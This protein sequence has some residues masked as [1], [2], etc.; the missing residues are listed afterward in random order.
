MIFFELSEEQAW[1][2]V[3]YRPEALIPQKTANEVYFVTIIGID[4]EN[5]YDKKI[6]LTQE[7]FNQFGQP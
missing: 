6:L 7:K 3:F 4:R 5:P 1:G 2:R